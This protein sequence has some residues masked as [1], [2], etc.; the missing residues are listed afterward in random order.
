MVIS[1]RRIL[2]YVTAVWIGHHLLHSRIHSTTR[3]SNNINYVHVFLHTGASPF[4]ALIVTVM[5]DGNINIL[6]WHNV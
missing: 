6:M 3:I 5:K 2:D 1:I 4:A